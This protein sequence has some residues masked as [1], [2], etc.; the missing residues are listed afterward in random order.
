[1][2]SEVAQCG[3]SRERVFDERGYNRAK[4]HLAAV[5]DRP[6]PCGAVDLVSDEAGGLLRYLPNVHAHADSQLLAGRPFRPASWRCIS[7]TAAMHALGE[8][9]VAKNESPCVP[10]SVPPWA[11][12]A[13]RTIA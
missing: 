4:Q 1:V 2:H 8:V 10:S 5:G 7:R 13:P 6:D 11:A 12:R 3:F 9:N